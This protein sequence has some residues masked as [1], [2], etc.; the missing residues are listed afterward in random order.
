ME[1]VNCGLCG[2]QEQQ[3]IRSVPVQRYGLAAYFQLV[4]C[5][6]CNLVY[7][8]PRPD[9]QES[10][11][12]YPPEYQ[13]DMRKVL[14]EAWANP[15]TRKGL[16]MVRRRRTPRCSH[17]GKLL[18]I[19]AASGI[20][21]QGQRELGWDVEGIEIDQESAEYARQKYGLT[22][23]TGDAEEIL[24]E[25][26][27]GTFDAVAMWHVLEHLHHP[28]QILREIC[29]VLKPGG[30]LIVEAPN[31][32]SPL[33]TLF[34]RYW[35]P[36]EIPRHLYHFTPQTLQAMFSRAGLVSF[37]V[38]GVPSAEV[39]SWSLHA[40][41]TQKIDQLE[42]TPLALNPLV[43]ALLFPVSWT[44]AQFNMSDH[45][46]AVAMK[47]QNETENKDSNKAQAMAQNEGA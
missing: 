18:E 32:G 22:I 41:R 42:T 15:I 33:V 3:V 24:P 46:A 39:V 7:L 16:E 37:Q 45:M 20:Y 27:E 34:G 19:G 11:A 8:N 14:Q 25:M 13:A 5:H 2:S 36:L 23:H 4:R 26:P 1:S 6:T 44:M 30:L 31:Y 40:L 17:K 35:F 12:Y 28:L 9:K 43:M 47:P 38:K 21:L 10:A 29:R